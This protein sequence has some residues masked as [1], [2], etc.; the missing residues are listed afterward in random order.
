MFSF[1]WFSR[2]YT[3]VILPSRIAYANRAFPVD[4]DNFRPIESDAE[5]TDAVV[6]W[7]HASSELFA[8]LFE[9]WMRGKTRLAGTTANRRP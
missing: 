3:L 5:A 9:D 6:L 1:R 8:D 7:W 4:D 2:F